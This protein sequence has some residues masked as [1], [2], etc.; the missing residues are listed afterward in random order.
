LFTQQHELFLLFSRERDIFKSIAAEDKDPK[1]KVNFIQFRNYRPKMMED[2]NM[3]KD[4]KSE[5]RMLFLDIE[6]QNLQRRKGCKQEE[7]LAL[8]PGIE[9]DYHG[10]ADKK[11]T[12]GLAL[13]PGI[14][15]DYHGQ[16][17]KKKRGGLAL[18]P[19]IEP[20]QERTALSTEAGKE[21][22]AP[23]SAGHRNLRRIIPNETSDDE[24]SSDDSFLIPGAVRIPGA[25]ATLDEDD[26]SNL[27]KSTSLKTAPELVEAE[28][29]LDLDEAIALGI[30][31]TVQATAVPLRRKPWRIVCGIACMLILTLAAILTAVLMPVKVPTAAPSET[32]TTSRAPSKTASEAPSGVPSEPPTGPPSSS[33]SSS[34]TEDRYTPLQ[35]FLAPYLGEGFPIS[36]TERQALYWLAYED[37]AIL[38]PPVPGSDNF[39]SLNSQLLERYIVVLFYFETGGGDWYSK[40]GWLSEAT[41]CGWYGVF[42]LGS[43]GFRTVVITAI[44]LRE[45][46]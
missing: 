37:A 40:A 44:E 11:T 19:G 43:V 15:P 46:L 32:P 2:D 6:A 31:Q 28:L 26:Q 21:R 13:A 36:E 38:M 22:D 1:L 23:H 14:E 16:A 5:S 4:K 18:A 29:A 41:I 7:D 42:C 27:W 3:D 25:N 33:P 24:V 34:P 10:R 8:A 9:P 39:D 17:D 30:Q 12:G 20:G 35:S 45:F